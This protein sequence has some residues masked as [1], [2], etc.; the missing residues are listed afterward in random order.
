M[1][2]CIRTY[3]FTL[4]VLVASSASAQAQFEG[5]YTTATTGMRDAKTPF[6]MTQEVSIKGRNIRT[7]MKSADVASGPMTMI[8]RGDKGMVITLFET[9]RVYI[10]MPASKIREMLKS[11]RVPSNAVT[12][13]QTGKTQKIL[14]HTCEQ[15][16]LHDGEATIEA[17][18]TRDLGALRRAMEKLNSIQ[19]NKA[20]QWTKELNKMKLFPMKTIITVQGITAE[21]TITS[22]DEKSLPNSLFEIPAGYSKREIPA[23]MPGSGK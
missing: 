19:M 8:Y 13:K 4:C 1:I 10:E 23:G 2:A 5:S 17:W 11:E 7:I 6:S 12:M 20:P 22:I 9:Q 18:A 15:I 14:N 21:T 16:I 3:A